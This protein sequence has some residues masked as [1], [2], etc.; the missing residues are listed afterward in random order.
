MSPEFSG[1]DRR[2]GSATGKEISQRREKFPYLANNC[3]RKLKVIDVLMVLSSSQILAG[4]VC[5]RIS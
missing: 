2:R 1:N 5:G 4:R 3:R